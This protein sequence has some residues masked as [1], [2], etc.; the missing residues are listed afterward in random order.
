MQIIVLAVFSRSFA[1]NHVESPAFF[2]VQFF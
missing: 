2:E 1:D